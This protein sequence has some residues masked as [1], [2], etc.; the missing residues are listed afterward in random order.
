MGWGSV[1]QWQHIC[2]MYLRLWV[3]STALHRRNKSCQ[4]TDLYIASVTKKLN[5][6]WHGSTHLKSL[7]LERHRQADFCEFWSI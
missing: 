5:G 2:P 4:Y 7:V 1:A 6:L 3:P